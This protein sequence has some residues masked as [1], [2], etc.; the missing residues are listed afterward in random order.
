MAKS[1]ISEPSNLSVLLPAL[2]SLIERVG[3]GP[4]QLSVSLCEAEEVK[5]LREQ[6]ASLE[7]ALAAEMASRARTESLFAHESFLNNELLDLCR[8]YKVPVP[9]KFFIRK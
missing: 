6:V 4:I 7:A 9:K 3:S 8:E 1:Q 2:S 5:A